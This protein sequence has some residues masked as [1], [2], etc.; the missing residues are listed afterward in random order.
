MNYATYINKIEERNRNLIS[1]L[2]ESTEPKTI[3]FDKYELIVNPGVFD[4]SLGEGSQIMAKV[5]HLF[6]G[7]SVLEIG[8]GTGAL[9]ILA[10]ENAEKVVATDISKDAI[11]CA[12]VNITKHNLIDKIELRKGDLFSVIN[13]AEIF[14]IIIFNPPFLNGSPESGIGHSYFDNGY[15]TLETFF[16]E[17]KAHLNPKGFIYLCF[18]GVGDVGYLNYLIERNGFKFQVVYSA[19]INNLSF[20]IY[21]I[22]LNNDD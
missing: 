22:I 14:D 15:N 21:Q 11:D 18:G 9:A 13:K 8:T 19:L 3:K 6:N 7:E 2:Q 5:K 20:F 10:A 4:P 1:K 17:V 16:L 12:M